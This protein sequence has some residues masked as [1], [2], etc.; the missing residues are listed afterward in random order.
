M[1]NLDPELNAAGKRE[2]QPMPDCELCNGGNSVELVAVRTW[3]GEI[4]EFD[5]V[6]IPCPRCS[7]DEAAAKEDGDDDA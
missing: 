1:T 3:T 5:A 6:Y 4:A 2:T 7:G